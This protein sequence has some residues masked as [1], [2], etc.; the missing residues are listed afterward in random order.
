M[1]SDASRPA[2]LTDQVLSGMT[3]AQVKRVDDPGGLGRVPVLFQGDSG[4][5]ESDWLQV[6]SFYGGPD[7]GAFFLPE[8]GDSVLVALAD[9]NSKQGFVLGFLWSGNA[10]PPVVDA[11]RQQD[12]RTIKTRQGKQLIFDDSKDGQ[13]T[14]IDEHQNTV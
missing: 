11:D 10:R 9:G 5:L 8:E 13:L 14:L 12:V 7:C 4:P 6:M 3:R 2:A 1:S